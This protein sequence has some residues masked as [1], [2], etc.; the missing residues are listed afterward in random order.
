MT[1]TWRLFIAIELPP[2]VSASLETIQDRLVRQAPPRTVR[3][4]QPASIHLTLK[5]LGESPVSQRGAL[6]NALQDAV[7]SHPSFSIT[8][9]GLG[10]FPNAQRPRVVWVGV[11]DAA[12]A[13]RALRDSVEMAIA[14]LG[15]PT[16]DRPFSPHLTIGRVDCSASRAA[17]QKLGSLIAA[18]SLGDLHTWPVTAVSLMRSE[19]KPTGAVY[20]ALLHAPLRS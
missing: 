7:S 3:W 6:Q 18:T 14:P 15:Y 16:E 1:E 13:L 4:V 12:G 11:R 8:V 2:E 17:V 19:L 9:G 20:T 5:F 10:C